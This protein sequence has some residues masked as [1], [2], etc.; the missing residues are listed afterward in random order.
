MNEKCGAAMK[1][2]RQ[3]VRLAGHTGQHRSH[4]AQYSAA[5]SAKAHARGIAQYGL[6]LEDYFR[7][8]DAQNGRCYICQKKPKAGGPRLSVDHCHRTGEVRGLLCHPCN[9]MLG[10]FHENIEVFAR[11]AEYL[12]NPPSRQVFDTP[13]RHVDAPPVMEND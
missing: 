7:L 3:C 1:Q 6:V 11:A 4:E 10:Y 8:H 9:S 13:R 12:T 2:G 5:L